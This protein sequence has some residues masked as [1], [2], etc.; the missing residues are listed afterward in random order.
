MES[1]ADY[2]TVTSTTGPIHGFLITPHSVYAETI[3]VYNIFRGV[4]QLH[5]PLDGS[6]L[7]NADFSGFDA[8]ILTMLTR[9][10]G[11]PDFVVDT[12][13]EDIGARL[14]LPTPTFFIRRQPNQ[15]VTKIDGTAFNVFAGPAL[16][17]SGN[18][19]INA[20]LAV[21]VR[22]AS[23]PG[24][25]RLMNP[26]EYGM[27][28]DNI[29]RLMSMDDVYVPPNSERWD[30]HVGMDLFRC[31]NSIFRWLPDHYLRTDRMQM[32]H[33]S[34]IAGSALVNN[35]DAVVGLLRD[36]HILSDHALGNWFGGTTIVFDRSINPLVTTIAALNCM[37]RANRRSYEMSRLCINP[38][39]LQQ[40]EASTFF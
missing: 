28:M 7:E 10:D 16:S 25:L 35:Q 29:D 36:H 40:G 14:S 21:W 18:V 23:G 19:P 38:L 8:S 4:K 5:P 31:N 13:R 11:Q 30:A 9:A 34:T 33:V 22:N 37:Y 32:R 1:A 39:E 17:E 2:L 6:P 27:S 24:S 26:R 20:L 15:D 3:A 12:T